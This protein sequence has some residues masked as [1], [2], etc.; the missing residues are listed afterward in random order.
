[1]VVHVCK[2]DPVDIE[3]TLRRITKISN[4]WTEGVGE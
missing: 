3:K 4:I 2:Q 1:M